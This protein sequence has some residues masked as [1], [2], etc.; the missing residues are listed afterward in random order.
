MRSGVFGCSTVP[1]V[2]FLLRAFRDNPL[3]VEAIVP[4]LEMGVSA[5]EVLGIIDNTLKEV[6]FTGDTKPGTFFPWLIFITGVY[7]SAQTEISFASEKVP[8]AKHKCCRSRTLGW[9]ATTPTAGALFF[10]SDSVCRFT[11]M[12]LLMMLIKMMLMI[13]VLGGPCFMMLGCADAGAGACWCWCWCLCCADSGRHYDER[14]A[15]A[16]ALCHGAR[17]LVRLSI[18]RYL[19]CYTRSHPTKKQA[20]KHVPRVGIPSCIR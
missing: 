7:V 3:A 14:A 17:R 13:P 5:E 1:R 10:S 6:R 20:T 18:Q 11:L 15:L 9:S 2:C 16:A 12:Y 4:L 8:G 19:R